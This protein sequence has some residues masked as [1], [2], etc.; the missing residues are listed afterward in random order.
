MVES[1]CTDIIPPSSL[2]I[3]TNPAAGWTLWKQMWKNNSVITKLVDQNKQ[4]QMALFLNAVKP[5]ALTIYNGFHFALTKNKETSTQ[6]I[7]KTHELYIFDKRDQETGETID[8]Y[9]T[10]LCNL[11]KSCN[12]CE[13]IHDS[14]MQLYCSRHERQSYS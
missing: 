6:K 11:A 12:F 3:K 8:S 7:N 13:G 1:F 4:Y 9:I 14:S 10:V 5:N 2:D